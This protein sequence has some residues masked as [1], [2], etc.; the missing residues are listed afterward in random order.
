VT[1]AAVAQDPV[2]ATA[3]HAEADSDE[4]DDSTVVELFDDYAPHEAQEALQEARSPRVAVLAGR[5]SGKTYGGG[6]HFLDRVFEDL[7]RL[8]AKGEHDWTRPEELNPTVKPALHYWCVAPTYTHTDYQLREIMDVLGGEESRLVLDYSQ[9]KHRLWLRGGILIEFKSAERPQQLVAAGLHG[10][11]VDEA[12]RVKGDTWDDNV[13]PALTE[14]GGWALFTSTP[15]GTANWYYKQIWSKTDQTSDESFE[16]Y[17]GLKF[18]TAD[19]TA[20]EG[21]VEEVE[22][23]RRELPEP[24]FRRNYR[25]DAHAFKGKVY[26]NFLGEAPHVVDEIPV[27]FQRRIGGIDWGFSNPGVLLEIGIDFDGRWWVYDEHYHSDLLKKPPENGGGGQTWQDIFEAAHDRGVS[28][29]W[30]D[31]S[32][33]ETIDSFRT[34]GLPVQ[35]AKNAV[36]PGIDAVATML[37]DGSS[38]PRLRIHE[39][40][41]HTIDE[42]SSYKWHDDKSKPVKE[43]DHTCD[44]LR[45]AVFTEMRKGRGV[46]DLDDFSLFN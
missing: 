33:P 16:D 35:K 38:G 14:Y 5:R 13:R 2:T 17:V 12:A 24:V 20:V 11:W 4:G 21:I 29:F 31:P 34:E 40:C 36:N 43:N 37:H 10:V 32:E 18:H 41:E 39:R 3:T 9:S 27:R 25:A 19:N 44:A 46:A 8:Q 15:L 28:I 22:K 23:A 26:T 45:Y 30:A 6:R 42:L 1:V 7:E